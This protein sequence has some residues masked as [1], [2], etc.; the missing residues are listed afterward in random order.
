HRID[1]DDGDQV[2]AAGAYATI[3]EQG[4]GNEVEI[5][6][7][8]LGM[9]E[10]GHTASLFPGMKLEPGFVI[11]AEAPPT[12]PIARRV[13]FSYSAIARARRVIAMITG[14]SKANRLREVL[15]DE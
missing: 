2:R 6:L 10:D 3:Y 12:S 1:A 5:D 14:A 9:G 15:L 8:L 4:A 13:T 7:V 11:P